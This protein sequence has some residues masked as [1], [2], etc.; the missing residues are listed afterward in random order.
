MRAMLLE[1]AGLTD[2][3]ADRDDFSCDPSFHFEHGL[4]CGQT[5]WSMLHRYWPLLSDFLCG[6][7]PTWPIQDTRLAQQGGGAG[8]PE[9]VHRTV[10]VPNLFTAPQ[11]DYA[12]DEVLITYDPNNDGLDTRHVA[13]A[14]GYY[15]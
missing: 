7:R 13:N 4:A 11:E 6:E 12:D 5:R 15:C 8:G 3:G 14:W 9:D 10:S 2:L 1:Q